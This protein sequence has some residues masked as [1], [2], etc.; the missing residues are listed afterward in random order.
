ML[1]RFLA[2]LLILLVS[3]AALDKLRA[4]RRDGPIGSSS[5]SA[6][7]AP[8]ELTLSPG[9]SDRSHRLAA[10]PLPGAV[11]LP[12]S[13]TRAG[14]RVRLGAEVARHYLDSL[15][16]GS[17]STV[18]RW[19]VG[20]DAIGLVIVPGG[21][22]GFVPEMVSEVRQALD[23]WSPAAVGLRFLEQADTVGVQMT[24][25]WS[26]TLE[27]DRAGATDVTWDKSGRIHRVTVYLA[28]RSPST[29]LPFTPE[30]RRAI[31]LHELGHAL[32]LPHSSDM[33]DAMYPIA[34]ETTLSDRD[35]F[36]LRLLYELPTGWIGTMTRDRL[37]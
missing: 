18:R 11:V 17:D 14:A 30:A 27:A 9:G 25:R 32:G 10:D 6:A 16:V 37:R 15:F 12:D 8:R 1:R 4:A 28:V 31:A 33:D 13:L 36:S 2:G 22:A 24:V 21:P 19:P 29:G 23:A 7:R 26:D 35:R 20:P 34:T 3:A 5:A